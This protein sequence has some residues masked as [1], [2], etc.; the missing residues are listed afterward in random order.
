[1]SAKA[2]HGF[3]DFVQEVRIAKGQGLKVLDI[4]LPA[5]S[6]FDNSG[7]PENAGEEFHKNC[8]WAQGSHKLSQMNLSK[9]SNRLRS[10]LRTLKA[11]SLV[12]DG[13]EIGNEVDGYCYNGDVPDGHAASPGEMHVVARGYGNFLKAASVVIREPAMY[14]QAKIITAGL[15]HGSDQYD[16]PPHHI[17]D[18]SRMIAMLHNLDGFDYLD[19]AQYHVD[20]YGTHIYARPNMIIK[21]VQELLQQDEQELR[22]DKPLWIT[23]WGFLKMNAFP[24]AKGQTLGEAISVMMKTF[25]GL[26]RV[27]PIG[28]IFFYSYNGWLADES[29]S[30][31]PAAHALEAAA[32]R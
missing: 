8:G 19:N 7:P 30:L 16:R 14:P 5:D 27:M 22:G 15:A 17:S 24:N 18:P 9:F 29:G 31:L 3:Q 13:F 12:I 2:P 10:Q 4:I 32:R 1:M 6:D 28:P 21:S 26:A 23:E 20:G 11:D 25:R